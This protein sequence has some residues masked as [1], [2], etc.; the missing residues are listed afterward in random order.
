[1]HLSDAQRDVLTELGNIGI[2]R[3]ARQL[4]SL[5]NEPIR[6]A[7]PRVELCTASEASACLDSKGLSMDNLDN[8]GCAGGMR[9]K[10]P[11]AQHGRSLQAD[12][13]AAARPPVQPECLSYPWTGP[14]GGE[15]AC[16]YQRMSG[17]LSGRIALLLPSGGS[18]LLFHD[19]LGHA[20]PLQG[21]DLR[22][23]EHEAMTE[24][25]NILISSCVS[26]MA[27]MLEL[28][29]DVSVPRFAE[30][31]AHDLFNDTMPDQE[32]APALL[33]HTRLTA[34]RRELEGSI[35]L[36]LSAAAAEKVMFAVQALILA[37]D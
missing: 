15:L 1:M 32:E 22:A 18:H 28:R 20:A 36:L 6:I 23:F 7:V 3:A 16:V 34:A 24:I 29:I 13:N 37:A 21:L 8:Y 26:A 11:D 10:A 27:D 31:T 5:L 14:K 30:A 25:G 2:S 9:C 19:L 17:E 35:M 12:G 33:I 4:S